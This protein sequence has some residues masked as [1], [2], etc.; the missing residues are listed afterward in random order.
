M[1]T[2]KL[3][4]KNATNGLVLSTLVFMLTKETKQIKLEQFLQQDPKQKDRTKTVVVYV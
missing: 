2:K 1:A 4:R 3:L